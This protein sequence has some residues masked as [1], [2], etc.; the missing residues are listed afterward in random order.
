MTSHGK[1]RIFLILLASLLILNVGILFFYQ[2]SNAVHQTANSQENDNSLAIAKSLV[3]SCRANSNWMNCYG[4]KLGTVVSM[5]NFQTALRALDTIQMVDD[6]TRNCHIIAHLMVGE[7]VA[8]DPS[9]WEHILDQLDINRCDY[10]FIHGLFEELSMFDPS[11]TLNE[12]TIPKFCTIVTE[13]KKGAWVDKTCAHIMGHLLLV[14]KNGNDSQAAAVCGKLQLS[15]Q[16]ECYGGIFMEN[17]ARDNLV[18]HGLASYIPWDQSTITMEEKLC[19]QYQ[20]MASVGCW[21]SMGDLYVYQSPYDPTKVYQ[22]CSQAKVKLAVDTCYQHSAATMIIGQSFDT[23]TLFTELC[24][25]YENDTSKYY[26]CMNIS[27]RDLLYSS[28][29]YANRGVQYCDA[30][31]DKY[32]KSCYTILGDVFKELLPPTQKKVLCSQVPLTYRTS[33]TGSLLLSAYRLLKTVSMKALTTFSPAS[34]SFVTVYHILKEG[35]I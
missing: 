9:N 11:F 20:G 14:A 29:R 28:T 1:K 17:Y 16:I 19:R 33:C 25:P 6:R 35:D 4:S 18:L 31:S 34:A 32:K 7:A 5:H 8:K 21:E 23:N 22:L 10:G 24:S 30:I 13:H 27:L 12:K 3:K 15:L 26:T 2:T